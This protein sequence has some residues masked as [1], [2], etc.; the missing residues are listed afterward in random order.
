MKAI[1]ILAVFGLF[2]EVSVAVQKNEYITLESSGEKI[3][4]SCYDLGRS[5]RHSLVKQ[6]SISRKMDFLMLIDLVL[7]GDVVVEENKYKIFNRLMRIVD[8]E[9]E[10]SGQEREKKGRKR[11]I[12]LATEVMAGRDAYGD[13][14]NVFDKSKLKLSYY[15]NE[16]CISDLTF[17]LQ[18]GKWMIAKQASACD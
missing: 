8:I 4:S 9:S 12:K 13:Q 10:G 7:C 14:L 17:V 16:A 1:V 5:T 2:S 11:S 3:A 15:S 6:S 18:R